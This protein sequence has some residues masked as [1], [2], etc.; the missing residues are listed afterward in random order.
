MQ[1]A[2]DLRPLDF[3]SHITKDDKIMVVQQKTNKRLLI[4]LHRDLREALAAANR[5]YVSIITT[6]YGRSFTVDG[7]SQ[8]MRDSITAG[9]PPTRRDAV[10]V[11]RL[12]SACRYAAYLPS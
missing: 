3:R 8:W 10:A 4:P 2:L 5:E 11:F 7:F 9:G 1:P 12:A 6:A